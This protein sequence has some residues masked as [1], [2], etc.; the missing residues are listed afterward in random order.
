MPETH[1]LTEL[2]LAIMREL[3]SRGEASVAEIWEALRPERGLAQTT[4]ATLLTRL[5]KRGVVGHETRARQFIYRPMV[6]EAEVRQTM[7]RDLTESL[8]AG[9]VA[10]LMSHLLTAREFDSGDLERLKT[11]IIQHESQ[12]RGGS[13]V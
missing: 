5:E 1:Q 4:V 11:L 13:H 8:F 7:V 10:E 9:N 2:Q 6:T 3:W 12:R